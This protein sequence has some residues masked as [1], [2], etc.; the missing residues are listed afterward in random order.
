MSAISCHEYR[1]AALDLLESKRSSS[2]PQEVI[3]T[4]H[5]FADG[6]FEWWAREGWPAEG[7][8]K[9]WGHLRPCWEKAAA[10]CSPGLD[11]G[12]A[13]ALFSELQTVPIEETDWFR[14]TFGFRELWGDIEQAQ[15]TRKMFEFI[16]EDTTGR[17][18]R[19]DPSNEG[20][21]SDSFIAGTFE[22]PSLSVLRERNKA[23]L[24]A[25]NQSSCGKLR[26]RVLERQPVDQLHAVFRAGTL[27][28]VFMVGSQFN[29][30]Q[31]VRC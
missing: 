4:L 16:Q 13:D 17:L 10:S 5:A 24:H 18:N 23:D 1:G 31:Q 26:W 29:C 9:T 3:A 15:R 11:P 12:T 21:V 7:A 22:R 30:L 28:S 2:A 25:I 20:G 19:I 27:Y 8:G 14:K 6:I